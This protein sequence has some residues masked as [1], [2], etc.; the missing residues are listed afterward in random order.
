MSRLKITK[1]QRHHLRRQL[2]QAQ[3]LRLYRRTLA[4]LEFDEGRSAADIAHMLGVTR[5]SVYNWLLTYRRSGSAAALADEVR[6]GRPPRW[7]DDEDRLLRALLA[8]SPQ[9]LGYLE[10]S[11]T[12]P[13]LQAVLQRRSGRCFADSTIRRALRRLDYVWKRPRYVLEPDPQREK[14]T[15]DSAANPGA[16]AP[17]RGIGTG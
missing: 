2:Q 5:Q 13:L 3:D 1:E 16:A 8:C 9:E 14:K 10:V 11:W 12:V 17:Q 6:E 4:V 15:A 7:E